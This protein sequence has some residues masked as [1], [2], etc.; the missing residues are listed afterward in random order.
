MFYR[1][2]AWVYHPK[3]DLL[4]EFK[5]ETHNAAQFKPQKLAQHCADDPNGFIEKT[6]NSYG[7]SLY[8]VYSPSINAGVIV[9][10]NKARVSDTVNL[11]RNILKQI[12]PEKNL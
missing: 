5:P 3:N 1:A 12:E 4:T 2:L 11:G 9:L 6:G 7:M 10:A 8:A